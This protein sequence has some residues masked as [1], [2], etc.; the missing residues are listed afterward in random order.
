MTT[1]ESASPS[2][3]PAG[4]F[5]GVE[6]PPDVEAVLN[7]Y[8]VECAGEIAAIDQALAQSAVR[9]AVTSGR[10]RLVP[11]L[12]PDGEVTYC[13]FWLATTRGRLPGVEHLTEPWRDGHL[14][15]MLADTES[16][17]IN[18]HRFAQWARRASPGLPLRTADVWVIDTAR[19][20]VE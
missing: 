18:W 12:A 4:V 13:G 9:G 1:H 7:A 16:T 5:Y 8:A 15:S 19:R 17:R 2:D 20:P 6:A 14:A 11:T 10:A 3:A